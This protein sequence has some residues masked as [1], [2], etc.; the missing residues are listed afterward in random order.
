MNNL[1][2]GERSK[3]AL[4]TELSPPEL[5]VCFFPARFRYCAVCVC[6][7]VCVVIVVVVVVVVF[8]VLI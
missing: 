4:D 8:L 6:V 1:N 7:C 3:V 2:R 5:L